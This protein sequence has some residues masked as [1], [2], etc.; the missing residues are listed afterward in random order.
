MVMARHQAELLALATRHIALLAALQA[1]PTLRTAA[2][3]RAK[4]SG[5]RR[6]MIRATGG[7]QAKVPPHTP[8]T[9]PTLRTLRTLPSRGEVTAA[10][11]LQVLVCV[12]ELFVARPSRPSHRSRRRLTRID[13]RVL[14]RVHLRSTSGVPIDT[15]EA[16]SRGADPSAS[17]QPAAAS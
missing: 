6:L 14:H 13:T 7:L 3:S 11:H 17:S 16:A 5:E 10:P 8:R 12:N 4:R 15:I 9:L 1:E 2:A